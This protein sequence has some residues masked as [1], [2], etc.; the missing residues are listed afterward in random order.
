M[1]T[2]HAGRARLPLHTLCKDILLLNKNYALAKACASTY[3]V[4]SVLHIHAGLLHCILHSL[5]PTPTN[6]ISV[7]ISLPSAIGVFEV[8]LSSGLGKG[9]YNQL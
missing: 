7:S 5:V 1:C 2:D 9:N 4:Q 3:I 6:Y 8:R